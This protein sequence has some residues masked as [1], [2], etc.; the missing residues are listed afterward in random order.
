MLE[1]GIISG[2]WHSSCIDTTVEGTVLPS[3]LAGITSSTRLTHQPGDGV[4]FAAFRRAIDDD[5]DY[6]VKAVEA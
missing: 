4:R 5:A 2:A 1:A 3:I 6:T